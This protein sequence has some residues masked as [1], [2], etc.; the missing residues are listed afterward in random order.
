MTKHN[1]TL[2]EEFHFSKHDGLLV[3]NTLTNR[4]FEDGINHDRI[5]MA[6]CVNA[7]LVS[8]AR[9]VNKDMSRNLLMWTREY[10]EEILTPW[11]EQNGGWV[12]FEWSNNTNQRIV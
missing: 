1:T 6:F 8:S 7:L 2:V 9:R 5:I 12:S 11:I 10:F 4:L 3:F